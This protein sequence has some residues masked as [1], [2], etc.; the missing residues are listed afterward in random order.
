M[1]GQVPKTSSDWIRTLAILLAIAV[2]SVFVASYLQIQRST[3]G[4]WKSINSVKNLTLALHNYAMTHATSL[5][6]HT[7]S[8]KPV[9]WR[10]DILAYLD[11]PDLANEYDRCR[12]WN[13]E[14]NAALGR[15]RLH[16]YDFSSSNRRPT[17]AN[18]ANSY[19]GLISGP[20]TVNPGDRPVTLQQISDGDGLGITLLIGEC[21]GLQLGW[22]EPRDPRVDREITGIELLTRPGQLSNRLLSAYSDG[23]VPVGFADGSARQLSHKIDPKILAAL[24]TINGGEPIGQQDF[25]P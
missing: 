8:E 2:V 11:R 25:I 4:R 14:P 22:T 16:I 17:A 5:P 19:Y 10:V 21:A 13:E 7:D 12:L 18:W 1:E 20:G 15:T 3:R 24:C 23:G 6:F 9:S